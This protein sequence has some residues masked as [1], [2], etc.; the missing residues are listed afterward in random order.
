ERLSLEEILAG[1][2][3]IK[4]LADEL[5]ELGIDIHLINAIKEGDDLIG[6]PY[7]DSTYAYKRYAR[8]LGYSRIATIGY[9]NKTYITYS[10]DLEIGLSD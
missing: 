1:N 2:L 3:Y 6:Y 8:Y 4:G 9:Y 5:K 10:Y 7:K